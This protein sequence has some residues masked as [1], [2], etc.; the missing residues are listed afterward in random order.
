[1]KHRYQ[2]TTCLHFENSPQLEAFKRFKASQ[3]LQGNRDDLAQQLLNLF[4]KVWEESSK[5]PGVGFV[6]DVEFGGRHL[7]VTIEHAANAFEEF[8]DEV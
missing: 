3:H 4:L 5:V 7:R 1:M 2:H 8:E 6:W